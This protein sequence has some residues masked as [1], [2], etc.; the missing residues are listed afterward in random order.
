MKKCLILLLITT[1]F[2]LLA[3]SGKNSK[4]K[5]KGVITMKFFKQDSLLIPDTSIN[6]KISLENPTSIKKLFGNQLPVVNDIN[7][8]A[9]GFK[10]CVLN[11]SENEYLKMNSFPGGV[12]NAVDHFEIGYVIFLSNDIN[13]KKS[14]FL[15]FATENGIRL[16]ISKEEIIRIKGNKYSVIK[17]KE[18]YTFRYVLDNF[19]KSSFLKRYNMPVYYEEF[20]LEKDKLVKFNFGFEYP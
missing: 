5:E 10:V 18:A 14:D 8:A 19:E 7:L 3:C 1:I 16:G 13:K 12:I 15:S 4:I 20:R 11:K 17:D 9:K 6:N 2:L